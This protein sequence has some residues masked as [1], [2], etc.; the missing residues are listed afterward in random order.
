MW[1]TIIKRWAPLVSSI[2]TEMK[3]I[4]IFHLRKRV[5]TR[6]HRVIK[7]EH[8]IVLPNN[9]NKNAKSDY[10]FTCTKTIRKV[11]PINKIECH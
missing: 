5:Y 8:Y 3:L 11:E 1:P 10:Y 6:L 4:N 7:N 2:K 9:Y